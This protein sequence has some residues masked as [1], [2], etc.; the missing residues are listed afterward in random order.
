MIFYLMIFLLVMVWIFLEKKSLNRIS[1][2]TPIFMLSVFSGIRSHDV[3]S[4]SKNYTYNFVNN[5]NAENIE[6]VINEEVGFSILNYFILIYT[7]NYFWLFFI[8]S[9]IVVFCYL[10]F[11]KKYSVNY[12]LSVFCFLSLGLYT[13]HFNGL[14]Q[15][16]AMAISIL[17]LPYLIEKNFWKFL[18]VIIFASLFHKSALV[19]SIFY[20]IVNFKLRIEYKFLLV[21]LLSLSF[22]GIGIEYLAQNNARY[23]TYT[24]LSEKSGGYITLAFYVLI[25]FFIYWASIKFFKNDYFFRKASEFYICGLA[26]LIPVA[27]LGTNASGPQRLLFY[28]V[29]VLIIILPNILVKLNNKFI[30]FFFL[31]L[32]FIYF[33]L[34]T[35]IFANLN[36]YYMNQIFRII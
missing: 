3:G 4:D 29:G 24:Q 22:S 20:I 8:S 35:S 11:I 31:I 18:I 1:F 2:W 15:G 14:R 19:L 6:I 30:Y 7:H 25:G 17:A 33:Y 27:M 5:I 28:F 32:G 10:Y 9:I 16:L 13:F 34:T 26:F 21:F 23:E 36:P 12:F